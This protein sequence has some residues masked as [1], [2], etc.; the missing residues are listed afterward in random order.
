MFCYFLDTDLDHARLFL[1][2]QT[3]CLTHAG[4]LDD[5]CKTRF[6]S[7]DCFQFVKHF[8][9]ESPE[10]L[11]VLCLPFMAPHK[12]YRVLLFLTCHTAKLFFF[13]SPSILHDTLCERCRGTETYATDSL[14]VQL[15][16]FRLQ[17][18]KNTQLTSICYV[19]EMKCSEKIASPMKPF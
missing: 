1:S 5:K 14:M 10:E 7:A 17:A 6:S 9:T 2:F 8:I 15:S 12:S 3:S 13:F 19:Q 18:F 4:D 11:F 16:G